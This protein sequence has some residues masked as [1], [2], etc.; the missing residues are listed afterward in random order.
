MINKTTLQETL[1]KIY[2]VP[3][4]IK[5]VG[6]IVFTSFFIGIL[7]IVAV[8][9]TFYNFNSNQLNELSVSI[10]KELSFQS[11]N[12][13]LDNDIFGLTKILDDSKKSNPDV[14][15]AFV[16][17]PDNQIFAS[18]FHNVFPKELLDVNNSDFKTSS[19]KKIKT[20]LGSVID[21]KE[22]ILN[23]ELGVLRVGI[24]KKHS[25]NVVN[26]LIMYILLI[27]FL[28]IFVSVVFASIITYL[29][30]QPIFLLK[31]ATKEISN[32]NYKIKVYSS[33]LYDDLGGLIESFNL[34][35]DK[36]NF[37]EKER[38]KK[39]QL[40]KEF[41]NKVIDAQEEERKRISREL[42]DELGQ[43]FA[44]LKMRIKTVEESNSL[45]ETKKIFSE[46]KENLLKEV[47]LIH[48]MAK[49]LRPSILDEMGLSKAIEFYLNDFVAAN[50]IDYSF[51]TFNIEQRRF[52]SHIE[53]SI[54][55]V[56]QEAVLNVVKH[57]KAKFL[58]V[59]LE[60]NNGILR[61]IIEDDGIGIEE[62]QKNN[63]G[64]G[65]Y[66]MKERITLLGGN[67]E[68]NSDKENGTI[69]IFSVP[70]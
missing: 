53:T 29:I 18:T 6:L 24:S 36:L 40:L 2:N 51:N 32:G 30:M 14:L 54:Y 10:A 20:N 39:E 19:V 55:R 9:K 28:G 64:F 22:P 60:W 4:Y 13:I 5:I 1:L 44:Y 34:M 57:S 68:I 65:I 45:N 37:L 38:E 43:F 46:L 7:T 41:V 49:N 42:H 69:I 17:S 62:N 66:S 16:E 12:Y 26:S 27:I 70:T 25:E 11:V 48:D 21:V 35:I 63:S 8:E 15:Y 33:R 50:N 47:N 61:G 58:K 59:F 67:L 56:V 52:D 3:F 23:G 31:K